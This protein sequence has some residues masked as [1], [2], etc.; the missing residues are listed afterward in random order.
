MKIKFL[1]GAQEV[2]RSAIFL[3]SGKSRIVMD[4]GVKIQPEPGEF[5][6]R[7]EKVDAI[8][9]THAHL[10]HCGAVPMLVGMNAP[11]YLTPPTAELMGLLLR[12][13][14]KIS[15]A[16]NYP[17][18]FSK[19]DMQKSLNS[20]RHVK[21]GKTFKVKDL[22][23]SLH[24]AGHIPGS[25]GV[26]VKCG[27]KSVFYT[28]DIKLG[29]QRLV[30]GCSL[31][32]EKIETLIIE[33]TYSDRNHPDA[34]ENEAAF[35]HEVDEALNM[36]EHVLIPSFAVGRSQEMLLA[37]KNYANY[38]VL[39]GMAKEA[40]EIALRN[41]KYLKQH[42]ELKRVFRKCR[43]AKTEKQRAAALKR[44]S[45]IV[46]T[47]GMLTGGP[48]AYYLRKIY[49]RKDS[50]VI[51]V[52]FQVEGSPGKILLDTN[53][54]NDGEREYHV[55]CK[56]ARFDFSS[57]AGKEELFRIIKTISP[58]KVFCVHGDNCP[59]FASEIKKTLGIDAYAPKIGD[60]MEI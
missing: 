55:R 39:D 3:D 20:A 6:L 15:Y 49:G 16:K 50:R 47:S 30:N 7:P 59:Q 19:E 41:E 48:S 35:L 33:S 4:Y 8:I 13:F 2:G 24:D 22:E 54:Y 27:K 29:S 14:L 10:D 23:C 9:P 44:P 25:S 40:T 1:G 58:K 57:H 12:D 56:I 28:G 32:K 11:V 53:M 17:H 45:V 51:F 43:K 31:P 26:L 52:G 60:E 5:P 21:Y 34:K 18:R 37:L 46:S 36:G 42:E 38:L